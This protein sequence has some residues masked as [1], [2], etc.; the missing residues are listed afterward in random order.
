LTKPHSDSSTKSVEGTQCPETKQHY[1]DVAVLIPCYNEEI[2]VAKVVVDFKTS[3]PGARVLVFDNNSSDRTALFAKNA[4]A[5]VLH[6]PLQGKGN[7][8]RQMFDQV[9]SSVYVMVDGDDTYP[10]S[11][12]PQL[13]TEFRK[14]GVDMVVGA[15]VVS[16]EEDSFRRFHKL[17]NRLVAGLVSKL[18]STRVTDILSGYRVLSRSYVK[19]VPLM[20]QGFEVETEMT[21][22]ALAKNFV[23]KEIPI[24]YGPRP[25]GS[26]S[27]LSTFSDGFLVLKSIFIIFK[28]FKPLVFFLL[29]SMLLFVITILAG[30]PPILDYLETRWVYHVPLAILAT[31]A[32]ILSALSLSIGVILHTIS[33]YHNENFEM[34]RRLLNK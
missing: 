29:L 20:S 11:A 14:S 17:G 5:T 6:A 8:V 34:M 4:G 33:K 2:T 32:G 28:D 25:E 27:K 18:F 31:G 16:F 13:V 10:A 3:L 9:D 19:T 21:L 23:I 12:A 22:Q 24:Q 1:D 15:R 26:Y 30:I 7:V